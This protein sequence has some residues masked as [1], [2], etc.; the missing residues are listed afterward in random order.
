MVCF[1]HENT[2]RKLVPSKFKRDGRSGEPGEIYAPPDFD[3][4]EGKLHN[5]LFT[6]IFRP[7]AFPELKKF[8]KFGCSNISLCISVVQQYLELGNQ[9]SPEYVAYLKI[10]FL[11]VSVI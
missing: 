7:G 1:T 5:Y 8:L 4:R 3:R 11:K 10:T 2:K 6:K 9:V